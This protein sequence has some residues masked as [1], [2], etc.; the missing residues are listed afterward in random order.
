MQ[1][2]FKDED[3]MRLNLARLGLAT[4]RI[5]RAVEVWRNRV[6]PSERK[7]PHPMMGKKRPVVEAG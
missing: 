5:E 1:I 6:H 7:P 3:D 2:E 4:D